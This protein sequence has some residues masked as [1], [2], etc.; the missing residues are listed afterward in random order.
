MLYIGCEAS[1]DERGQKMARTAADLLRAW[2]VSFGVLGAGEQAD[3]NEIRAMGESALFE[4]LAKQNIEAFGRLGVRKI[5]A[6][7]PHA[8][9]AFKNLYPWL[10]G[11]FE[12]LHYSQV[13]QRLAAGKPYRGSDRPLKVTYHDPCYLGRHNRQYDAPRQLIRSLPGVDLVEMDRARADALCCGGGGGNFFTGVMA[14]GSDSPSRARV[15]EATETGA[16]VLAVAC[17]ACA[18]MLDDAVK[19]EELE[20]TLRV[21]D[22]AELVA[23][24]L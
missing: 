22:L 5:I 8:Y 11:A 18:R 13:L 24:R 7:S 2:G 1:F 23:S 3:G 14:G 9:H 19:A 21:L 10:G 12:V 6:L 17:P 4:H 20:E 15:R 16:S